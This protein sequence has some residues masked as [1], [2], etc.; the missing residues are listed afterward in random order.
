MKS[1]DYRNLSFWL[2]FLFLVTAVC[3]ASENPM[4]HQ[5]DGNPCSSQPA[6]KA[7]PEIIAHR[8]SSAEAPENT[9][10]AVQL[11]WKQNADAVEID[12][13]LSK[14]GRIVVIHD[15]DT[16]RVAGVP[17]PVAEQ[18]LA[19]LQSLDAGSWKGPQWA[20]EKIPTLADILQ[21]IPDGK[22]LFVEIKCGLDILPELQRVVK[23]SKKKPEQIVFISFGYDTCTAVKKAFPN[24]RV[25]WLSEV[26]RDPNTQALIPLLDDL[27]LA[28]QKANLDGV[29]LAN[30][31]VIDNDFAQKIHAAGLQLFVWTVDDPAEA[32]R[33]AQ[34]GVAG[35]T[36]NQPK[37]LL[38][39]L[40]GKE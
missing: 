1:P 25:Y 18:T 4:K 2:S 9:L 23:E 38:S 35:I 20:G 40:R 11:A 37:Q 15:G 22:K 30:N 19:E 34:A 6:S 39:A 8:G 32:K 21:T 26:K 31:G 10:A 3:V 5:T 17:K 36:T 33:L 7:K 12:V 24:H 28:A 14:D 13:H 27:I 16:N 29:D